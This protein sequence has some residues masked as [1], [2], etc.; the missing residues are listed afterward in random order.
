MVA[1]TLCD[2]YTLYRSLEGRQPASIVLVFRSSTT[3]RPR[4]AQISR[5]KKE[6]EMSVQGLRT[7]M[8][9]WKKHRFKKEVSKGLWLPSLCHLHS[10]FINQQ[11]N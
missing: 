8:E 5:L 7:E 4:E 2:T 1:V 3:Q 10:I 11:Q 6:T 9:R